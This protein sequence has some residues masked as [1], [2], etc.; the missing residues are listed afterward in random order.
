MN[1]IRASPHSVLAQTVPRGYLAIEILSHYLQLLILILISMTLMG[2]WPLPKA[3]YP[4]PPIYP[5]AQQVRMVEDQEFHQERITTFQTTDPP[6]AVL[7]F[8]KNALL[9][10]G[11]EMDEDC[12]NCV[13][14]KYWNGHDNP[15]F[16][17]TVFILSVQDGYTQVKL[18]HVIAGPFAW[19]DQ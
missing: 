11:W 6:Q 16:T 2:C 5:G 12:A 14:F 1:Q 4:Q 7:T 18:R 10:Q 15:P 17:F 19:P 13:V 9:N 8:Y 3:R